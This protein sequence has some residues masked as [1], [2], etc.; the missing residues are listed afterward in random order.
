MGVSFLALSRKKPYFFIIVKMKKAG[1]GCTNNAKCNTCHEIS[2]HFAVISILLK[3]P[4]K[5]WIDNQVLPIN[6]LHF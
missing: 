6:I 3:R 5:P 2:L 1:F 4:Q